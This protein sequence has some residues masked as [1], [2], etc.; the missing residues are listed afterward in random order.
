MKISHCLLFACLAACN[1]IAYAADGASTPSQAAAV[2]FASNTFHSQFVNDVDTK[3]SKG[4]HFNWYAGKW[5]TWGPVPVSALQF[6]AGEGITLLDGGN[7]ANYTIGSATQSKNAAQHWVGTAFGGGG[8][9][10]AEIKFDPA[11]VDSPNAVGFPAWWL[12]PVEHLADPRTDQWRGEAANFEHFVEVDIFEYNQQKRLG[13]SPSA[14]SGATHEWYGVYKQTCPPG[15]CKVSN[16]NNLSRFNNFLINVPKGT[17]F[18]EFHRYGLLWVPATK[19]SEGYIQY[20][21]DGT[22]TDDRLSW[23]QFND[24]RGKPGPQADWTFGVV[25]RMHMVLI[26]GTGNSQPLAIRSVNVWQKSAAENLQH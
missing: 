2:G 5:F 26:L 22:A 16:Y 1:D 24:Q 6:N 4:S 19:T 3:D 23:A 13:P 10:E 17:N 9:F 7:T 21:F 11:M 25:D 12:E 15:F 20:Y 14:Y 18:N 8:Y